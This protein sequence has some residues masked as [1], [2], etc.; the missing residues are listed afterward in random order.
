MAFVLV[1]VVS[2]PKSSPPWST[3]SASIPGGKVAESYDVTTGSVVASAEA[4]GVVVG[5]CVGGSGEGIGVASF[6]T[7]IDALVEVVVGA[8]VAVVGVGVGVCVVTVGVGVVVV[9][10]LLVVGGGIVSSEDGTSTSLPLPA[11]VTTRGRLCK[12]T[13]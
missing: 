3:L 1:A 4:V 13:A 8:A 5:A 2:T 10:T 7:W 9:E 6:W 12:R 11:E